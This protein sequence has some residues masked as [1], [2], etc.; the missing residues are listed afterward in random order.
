MKKSTDEE[1]SKRFYILNTCVGIILLAAIFISINQFGAQAWQGKKQ[2]ALIL[3]G[4]RSMLGWNH[5]QY[6]EMKSLTEEKGYD[7]VIREN[8]SNNYDECLKIAEELSQRGVSQIFFTN[9]C[10]LENIKEFEKR[11]PKIGFYTIETMSLLSPSGKYSVYIMEVSYL[12]G[13]LAG[14]RTQTGKIGYI[15]PFPNAEICQEINAFTLGVKRMKPEAEVLV[16]WTGN[17]SNAQNEEQAVQRMKAEKV[18]VLSYHQNGMTVARTAE[19][20]GIKFISSNEEYPEY[21]NYLA[22]V[23]INWAAIYGEIIRMNNLKASYKNYGIGISNNK[24]NL[25][26]SAQITKRERVMLDLATWE[27]KKGRLIF[28]GEL[29]D[30]DGNKISE[31]NETINLKYIQEKMNWLIKG[32][33]VLGN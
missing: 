27:I 29:Y 30:K 2:I 9:G 24:A 1:L 12:S 13:I 20:L 16:S 28:S 10:R 4:E 21:K 25:K 6:V 7:L 3:P 5:T 32:V 33:R 22:A 11:Y 14:M 15:A 31:T 23:K 18:D 17:W 26:K 8:I 19:N